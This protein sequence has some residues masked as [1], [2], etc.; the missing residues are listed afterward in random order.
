M[1]SVYKLVRGMSSRVRVGDKAG[2]WV[3]DIGIQGHVSEVCFP[4]IRTVA[5]NKFGSEAWP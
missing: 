1:S 5:I 3:L 2:V 4:G